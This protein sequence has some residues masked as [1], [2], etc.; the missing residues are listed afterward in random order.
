MNAGGEL[1]RRAGHRLLVAGAEAVL[2]AAD[3]P[4]YAPGEV[5]VEDGRIAAVGPAGSTPAEWRPDEVVDA[6][7]AVVIPGLVNAH[8][9]SGMQMLRG[10]SEDLAFH[11]WLAKVQA[12]EDSLTPEDIRWSALL[13]LAEQFRFGVTAFADMHFEMDQVAR[14]VAE[15]GGRAVLSR[16]LVGVSDR[17]DAMLDQ[18]ITL[19]RDWHGAAEGRITTMLAPHAPYTCPPAYV[20][21]V[22]AASAELGV[23][24]HIHISES[25]R[26]QEEHLAQYGETPTATMAKAGLFTRPTLIAHFV[27]GTPADVEAVAEG[28]A[29]IAHCPQSN[30]KLANGAAPLASWLSAGVT[31]GLGTDS[32]ASNNNL[33]LWEELRLAPLLAK[34]I[35]GDPTAVPAATAF[36]L[37]TTGGA[38]AVGLGGVAGRLAPGYAADLVLVDWSGPHLCPTHDYLANL[39]FAALG[40]DVRLTMV[41][42]RVVYDRGAFL[43]LDVERVKAEVDRRSD[44]LAR[45]AAG[46]GPA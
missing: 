36:H 32:V 9:H 39:V 13:A 6:R 25:R 2:T 23:G 33:N 35:T 3:G 43:T 10:Y 7:G 12:L 18:G 46:S 17:A 22:V 24:L 4:C 16:G 44:H 34:G 45:I 41:A 31:V 28:G 30:L 37:A 26:E 27:H 19:C 29:A 15:S 42:G 1:A 8:T 38:A 40:S 14:A 11:P 21:R 20:E 5:A